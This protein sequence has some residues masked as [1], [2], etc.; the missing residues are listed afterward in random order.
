[1]KEKCKK[2][3][4]QLYKSDHWTIKVECSLWDREEINRKCSIKSTFK[5]MLNS[6]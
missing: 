4:N 6:S 3:N 2:C 1:M 5:G